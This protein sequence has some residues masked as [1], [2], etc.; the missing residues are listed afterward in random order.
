MTA[1]VA[2]AGNDT[3]TSHGAE[4]L[5]EPF[6][7]NA[8]KARRSAPPTKFTVITSPDKAPDEKAHHISCEDCCDPDVAVTLLPLRAHVS[9]AVSETDEIVGVTALFSEEANTTITSFVFVVVRVTVAP[10]LWA[11]PSIVG[12]LP[13]PPPDE[14]FTTQPAPVSVNCACACPQPK[15]VR[16]ASA[17]SMRNALRMALRAAVTGA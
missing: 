4:E 7:P 1:L 3:F 15:P 2:V 12:A 9:P 16:K 6:T 11:N 14:H 5:P 13:P 8:T 17:A 10:I